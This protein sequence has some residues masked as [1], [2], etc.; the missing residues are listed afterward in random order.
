MLFGFRAALILCFKFFC[1]HSVLCQ[2]SKP[3][4]QGMAPS[5]WLTFRYT[6]A[7]GK[8]Y[9]FPGVDSRK[10]TNEECF[11]RAWLPVVHGKKWTVLLGPN[12]RTEQFEVKTEGENPIHKM[13]GWN[14]RT[15]GLDITSLVKLD[16]VS[17]IVAT[18]HF[19][20]SGNMAE[21]SLSQIPVNYTVSASYLRKMAANKEIGLGVVFNQSF[22]RT[23][24]PVLIFNY[25]FAPN[26][27]IEIMLPKRV[28]LRRNFSPKDILYLKA[29]SVTRTYYI[30]PSGTNAR[31]VCRRV[32][33]DMG[34]SYNRRINN[35]VGL[36]VSAGYRKNLRTR[37]I[38]GAVPIRTSGL[39]MTVDL[40]VTPPK[41]K[42]KR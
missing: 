34:V 2:S 32:D 41:F 39:A 20:K 7:P 28:A 37:L 40:Y 25:N 1:I 26:A 9:G 42:K 38:D 8:V 33:V 36:E 14:L 22:K 30:N 3:G 16:S 18:S 29:E 31:D 19:N 12:Y 4:M 17:W 10:Y 21:L 5:K 15:I 23:L 11:V 13:S 35:L 24:L 6:H 27:G